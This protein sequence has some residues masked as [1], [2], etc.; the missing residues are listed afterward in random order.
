V[1]GVG[2]VLG[3]EPGLALGEFGGGEWPEALVRDG[4]EVVVGQELEA[5]CHR[6]AE[7]GRHDR[8]GLLSLGGCIVGAP[9]RQ[10]RGLVFDGIVQERGG[11]RV[12]VGIGTPAEHQARHLHHVGDVG[13]A[14]RTALARVEFLGQGRGPHHAGQ[15]G[16]VQ[17]AFEERRQVVDVS[18]H[19]SEQDTRRESAAA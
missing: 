10:A 2:H 3:V 15:R 6:H 1:H 13:L 19:A 5:P 17:A 8:E 14:V 9:L 12:R 11:E 7:R 18:G 4:L 16:G